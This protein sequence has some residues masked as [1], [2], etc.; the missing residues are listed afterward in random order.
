MAR[1]R[2]SGTRALG[3]ALAAVAL[4]VGCTKKPT[5]PQESSG[6]FAWSGP[7]S[8]QEGSL[9]L[10]VSVV[11]TTVTGEVVFT[12]PSNPHYHLRGVVSG[13][14]LLLAVDPAYPA[15]T[16]ALRARVSGDSLKGEM[17]GGPLASSVAFAGHVLARHVVTNDEVHEYSTGG[18]ALA[19]DGTWIWLSTSGDDDYMRLSTDGSVHDHVTVL[20]GGYHWTSS[21]LAFDGRLMWGTLPGAYG[22]PVSVEYSEVL[23]FDANGR[24]PDSLRLWQRSQGMAWDGTHLRTL[25]DSWIKRLDG[26]GAI[27]DSMKV[28]I[29]D[30][31]HLGYDG[32]HFWTLG[33]YMKR[34]YEINPLGQVVA[35]CDLPGQDTGNFPV[36]IAAEGFHLWYGESPLLSTRLHR[37]TLATPAPLGS[38]SAWSARRSP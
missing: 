22:P 21:T 13:D 3:V 27:L 8:G 2:G 9:V 32:S 12:D 5:E 6:R 38:A 36:G 11:G 23:A 35:I 14:S 37:L 33:W 29:P 18:I 16:F 26:T 10:D 15:S 25:K 34:L 31:V 1:T 7:Y 4:L 20:Y 24:A 30:P 19:Y 17:F 28:D